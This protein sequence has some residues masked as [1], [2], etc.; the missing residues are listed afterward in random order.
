[1][2]C[3]EHSPDTHRSYLH[4]AFKLFV[5]TTCSGQAMA[6]AKLRSET[7]HNGFSTGGQ[8]D[9]SLTS[10]PSTNSKISYSCCSAVL[11]GHSSLVKQ[12]LH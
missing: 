11:A 2:A 10:C 6:N 8:A 3:P 4:V 12:D 9:G 7:L 5:Q 1:M